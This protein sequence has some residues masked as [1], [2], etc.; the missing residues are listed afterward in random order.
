MYAIARHL[1]VRLFAENGFAETTLDQIAAAAGVARATFYNYFKSKEDVALAALE[2]MFQQVQLDFAPL[3]ASPLPWRSKIM[4]FLQRLIRQS[5]ST[6]ELIW[7]WCVESI[8]RGP[9]LHSSAQFHHMLVDLF[10]AGQASGAVRTD[11]SP[12]DM[13]VDLGGIAFAQ[14]AVWYQQEASADL[15][16][17]L[18]AAAAMYLD[19]V[20]L[21]S[22]QKDDRS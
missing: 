2:E 20:C 18:C 19:G 4:H 10:A 1:D 6:R 13:A 12:D 9:I 3:L 16:D 21:S 5:Y 14:I 15:T 22:N 11:R 17:R 8:K 7:V